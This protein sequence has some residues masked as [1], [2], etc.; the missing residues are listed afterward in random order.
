[1]NLGLVLYGWSFKDRCSSVWNFAGFAGR[2]PCVDVEKEV[3]IWW[4]K[5]GDRKLR[6]LSVFILSGDDWNE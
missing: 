4:S 1:M 6:W 3:M 5:H 2:D